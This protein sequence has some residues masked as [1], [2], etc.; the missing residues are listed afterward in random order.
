LVKVGSSPTGNSKSE[1]KT[2]DAILQQYHRKIKIMGKGKFIDVDLYQKEFGEVSVKAI[3]SLY[4]EKSGC[5]QKE[6]N[7]T[8]FKRMIDY[9]K[10]LKEVAR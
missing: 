9:L 7:S 2:H 5:T 10:E 8:T 3:Y 6:F 1:K 4:R